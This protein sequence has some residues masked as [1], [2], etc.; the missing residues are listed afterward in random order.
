MARLYRVVRLNDRADSTT[1]TFLL[2]KTL[3]TDQMVHIS[4]KDFTYGS[5]KWQVSFPRGDNKQLGTFLSIKN[6]SAGMNVQLDVSFTIQNKEHFTKN[7]QYAEK[8][9]RYSHDKPMNGRKN[10]IGLQELPMRGFALDN[11]EYLIDVELRNIKTW[12]EQVSVNFCF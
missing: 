2:P 7:E 1:F 8:D 5:H 11:G 4:S 6:I 10:F 9:L 3:L 12:F